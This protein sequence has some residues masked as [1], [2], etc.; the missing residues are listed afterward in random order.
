MGSRRRG[1]PALARLPWRYR[2][3]RFRRWWAE[4]ANDRYAQVEHWHRRSRSDLLRRQQQ[5]LCFCRAVRDPPRLLQPERRTPTP[6]LRRLTYNGGT[7]FF[8]GTN[9]IQVSIHEHGY[10][11]LTGGDDV[12]GKDL[13]PERFE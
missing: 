2:H 5:S 1:R 6:V 3:S 9:L 13:Q 11:K 4:R 10:S 12:A 8:N 7:P